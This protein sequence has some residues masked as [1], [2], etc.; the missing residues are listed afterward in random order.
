MPTR[1]ADDDKYCSNS[2]TSHCKDIFHFH[3]KMCFKS[4]KNTS[5]SLIWIYLQ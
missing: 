5:I 4:Y 1:T 2:H 3:Y